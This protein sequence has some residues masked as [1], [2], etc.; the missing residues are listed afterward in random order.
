MLHRDLLNVVSKAK[1]QKQKWKITWVFFKPK[2]TP[3]SD[4]WPF[5]DA[6]TNCCGYHK[7]RKLSV[8]LDENKFKVNMFLCGERDHLPQTSLHVLYPTVNELICI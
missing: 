1:I 8:A 6:Q 4:W 3:S 7:G 2:N 5:S